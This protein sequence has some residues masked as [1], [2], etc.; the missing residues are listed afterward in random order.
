MGAEKGQPRGGV[1]LV[2]QLKAPLWR[3]PVVTSSSPRNA[4]TLG[5]EMGIHSPKQR[6]L[7][8][9]YVPGCVLET[10]DT[11]RNKEPLSCRTVGDQRGS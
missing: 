4:V 3:V 1:Q 5:K 9:Y 6:L 10:G 2:E 11:A 8:T 7:S